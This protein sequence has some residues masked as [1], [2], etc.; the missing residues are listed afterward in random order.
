[1]ICA[2]NRWRSQDHISEKDLRRP[3]SLIIRIFDLKVY[4]KTMFTQYR[5]EWKTAQKRFFGTKLCETVAST[6]VPIRSVKIAWDRNF[7]RIGDPW[8][9]ICMRTKV[10]P[11]PFS[12]ALNTPGLYIYIY[13]NIKTRS[14]QMNKSIWQTRELSRIYS[15]LL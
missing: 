5:Y 3:R 8:A 1:M 7:R 15:Y 13:S 11:W 14:P 9:I 12:V 2:D 4:Y 6:G 10:W